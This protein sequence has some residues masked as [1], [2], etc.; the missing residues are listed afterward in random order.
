MLALA[1]K[2]RDE[3]SMTPA[4]GWAEMDMENINEIEA[5]SAIVDTEPTS[6]GEG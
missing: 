3:E 4:C 5:A 6:P 2:Y 1:Q